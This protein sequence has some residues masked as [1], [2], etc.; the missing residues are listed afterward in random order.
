MFLNGAQVFFLNARAGHEN[1]KDWIVF[2]ISHRITLL[3]SDH[4]DKYLSSYN[5]SGFS[6]RLIDLV[7]KCN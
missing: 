4:L 2:A 1:L 5:S 7:P 6:T 3:T